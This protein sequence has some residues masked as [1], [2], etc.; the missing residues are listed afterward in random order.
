MQTFACALLHFLR[1]IS[2]LETRIC[3]ERT[4]RLAAQ[5]HYTLATRALPSE[6]EWIDATVPADT[7]LLQLWVQLQDKGVAAGMALHSPEHHY[8]S[9]RCGVSH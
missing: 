8:W 3:N 2:G 7:G 5:L 4:I 6:N 9:L 1:N